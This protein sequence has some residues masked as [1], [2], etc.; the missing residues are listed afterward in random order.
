[1]LIWCP[2]THLFTF[3]SESGCLLPSMPSDVIFDQYSGISFLCDLN[4]NIPA[5]W[6]STSQLPAQSCNKSKLIGLY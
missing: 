6:P 4:D 5:P 3:F 1:M 2:I